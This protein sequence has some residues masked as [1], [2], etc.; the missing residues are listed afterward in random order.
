MLDDSSGSSGN[1]KRTRLS[2]DIPI[3]DQHPSS[4]LDV[5]ALVEEVLR[6][7]VE[8]FDICSSPTGGDSSKVVQERLH[9]DMTVDEFETSDGNSIHNNDSDFV[10]EDGG[11]TVI[12]L[13]E[14]ASITSSDI[15]LDEEFGGAHIDEALDPSAGLIPL[16]QLVHEIM[17]YGPN[18][19]VTKQMEQETS[20]DLVMESLGCP[21]SE[22]LR[23]ADY[24]GK[25][26]FVRRFLMKYVYERPRLGVST[27]EDAVQL[28]R[29]ARRILV[30]TGAGISVS[31]GI[32][33]FRSENG[34][35]DRIQSKYG[36]PEPECMFDIEFF[37]ID[38]E[39]FYSFA[40]ELLPKEEFKPSFSHFFI[41]HLEQQGKLLRQF[42]QNIDTLEVSVGIERVVYCHGTLD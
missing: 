32:P 33:D 8:E 21:L 11:Y 42:T 3:S 27:V 2:Q 40:K 22:G 5:D 12:S 9:V 37:R 20:P 18:L 28:I 24:K 7:N 10:A 15:E 35:Y 19:F 13:T 14:D 38:P 26:S 30:L 16:E 34:L 4:S 39:P 25:W 6:E 17:A 31:S 36:L 1:P 29:N 41:R 23:Y